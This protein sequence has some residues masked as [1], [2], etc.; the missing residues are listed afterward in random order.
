MYTAK[1][2]LDLDSMLKQYSPLVR[3]LVGRGRLL[4]LDDLTLDQPAVG[5]E[6]EAHQ[7][8]AVGDREPVPAL[9]RDARGVEE[10]LVDEGLGEVALGS[11]GGG[12]AGRRWSRSHGRQPRWW[13][14]EP[15]SP[16]GP[17]SALVRPRAVPH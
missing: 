13:C 1:G 7:L 2:Q 17:G 15:S 8:R 10:A 9:D 16:D 5:L 6:R 4:A 3:R 11:L 12:C 14:G